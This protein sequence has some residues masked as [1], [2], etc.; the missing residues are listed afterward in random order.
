MNVHLVSLLKTTEK[1]PEEMPLKASFQNPIQ[2]S[3]VKTL[4]A[5][6]QL[7]CKGWCLTQGAKLLGDG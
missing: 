1:D 4:K 5:I 7:S 3:C 2:N 6:L